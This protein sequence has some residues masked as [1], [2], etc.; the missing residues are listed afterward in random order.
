MTP[1]EATEAE[2]KAAGIPFTVDDGK[3]K[4][5]IQVRFTVR[6]HKCMVTCSRSTS[7]HRASLNARHEVRRA[8]RAALS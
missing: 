3:G 4:R 5:H 8:I 1:L 2:L 6:G 7:D